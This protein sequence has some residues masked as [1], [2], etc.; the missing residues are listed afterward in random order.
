MHGSPRGGKLVLI[1][2]VPI[3]NLIIFPSFLGS[4]LVLSTWRAE[5]KGFT[6][7]L[8]FKPGKNQPFSR[9]HFLACLISQKWS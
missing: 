6:S 9:F 4:K 3:S 2:F 1:A 8:L 5:A 7:P